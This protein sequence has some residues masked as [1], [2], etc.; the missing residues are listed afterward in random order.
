MLRQLANA[1]GGRYY[2][3]ADP[4]ELPSIFIKEAKTL[5]R[6]MIQEEEIHPL[7]GHPSVVLE[8]I[9]AMPPLHGFVL[10]SLK[11]NALTENVLY[12]Q[13]EDAASGDEQLDPCWRSGGT[14]WERPPRSRR[15]CPTS[16][17]ATG[18]TGRSTAPSSNS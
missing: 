7:V 18:W 3:P 5:K 16:G 8:G 12:A 14:D 2:F 13:L 10:T 6:S 9:D 11:E 4:N 15:H 17:P 1:T